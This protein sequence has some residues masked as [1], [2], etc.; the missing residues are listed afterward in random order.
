M[1]GTDTDQ[2]LG[3]SATTLCGFLTKECSEKK[4]EAVGV[5]LGVVT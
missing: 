5:G 3:I 1:G 2:V 4:Y